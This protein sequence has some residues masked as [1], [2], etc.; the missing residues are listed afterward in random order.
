MMM[1]ALLRSYRQRRMPE[2]VAGA[3]RALA[4]LRLTTTPMVLVDKLPDISHRNPSR[5][6]LL[7]D[8]LSSAAKGSSAS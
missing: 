1:L 5:R 2:L 8:R 4:V 7:L 3:L 6:T